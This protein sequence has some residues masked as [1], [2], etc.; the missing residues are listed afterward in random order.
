MIDLNDFASDCAKCAELCCLA[1]AFDQGDSFAHSKTAG[2]PCH[3]LSPATSGCSIHKDLTRKG[4]SGCVA[5]QCLGAGQRVT[6]LFDQTWRDDP[7]LIA[8]MMDAFRQMRSVQS[9]LQLLAAAQALTLPVQLEVERAAFFT[10][11]S[12]NQWSVDTLQR[13]ETDGVA[14]EINTWLRGLA[15]FVSSAP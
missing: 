11:L 7:K 2:S 14:V 8:P 3:N 12:P 9:C 5:Y 10:Q 6:A 4:Y 15:A 13:F 1:L